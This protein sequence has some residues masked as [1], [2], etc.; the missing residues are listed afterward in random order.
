V[1]V[2]VHISVNAGGN[3]C[4]LTVLIHNE[5]LDPHLTTSYSYIPTDSNKWNGSVLLVGRDLFCRHDPQ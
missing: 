1:D 3:D 5:N 4:L 2:N